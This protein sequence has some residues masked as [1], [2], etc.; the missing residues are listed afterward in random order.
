MAKR[1]HSR[2]SPPRP[3]PQKKAKVG[4]SSQQNFS[5]SKRAQPWHPLPLPPRLLHLPSFLLLHFPSSR[6]QLGRGEASDVHHVATNLCAP[7]EKQ[8]RHER[9][10][11]SRDNNNNNKKW[12]AKQP[13]NSVTTT[14]AFSEA[15]LHLIPY[16][17]GMGKWRGVD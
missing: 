5:T 1:T 13:S 9:K 17:L 2:L 7:R 10:T 12:R 16:E 6:L 14:G 15:V 8:T 3:R 4:A 11:V